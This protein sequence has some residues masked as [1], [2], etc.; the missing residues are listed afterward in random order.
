M[1]ESEKSISSFCCQ[2]PIKEVVAK[3]GAEEAG[4][5]TFVFPELTSLTLHNLLELQ[6]FYPGIHTT[7][8]P[9][10][11]KLKTIGC[12]KTDVSKLFNIQ[13]IISEDQPDIVGPEKVRDLLY[14]FL[15]C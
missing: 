8:W 3:E 14:F 2:K 7:K 15:N 1:P 9:M 10:L 11:E 5:R 6:C 4:D 13:K 12:G